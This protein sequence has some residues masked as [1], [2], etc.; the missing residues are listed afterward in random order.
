L[1]GLV[2]DL[3]A[4]NKDNQAFLHARLALGE[5]VLEPYKERIGRW[6]Y[7]DIYRHQDTSVSKAKQAI[8]DYKKAVNDPA[9]L[10]RNTAVQRSGREVGRRPQHLP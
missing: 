1:L 5:D 4:A 6:I 10:R 8:S 2:Q 9:G 7:P 3:Y